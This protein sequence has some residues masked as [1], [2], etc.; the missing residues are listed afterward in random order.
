MS[1][2]GIVCI[3]F[4]VYNIVGLWFWVCLCHVHEMYVTRMFQLMY[5]YVVYID[6]GGLV[7]ILKF[8]YPKQ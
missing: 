8:N 2:S 7:R 6:H 1:V 4:R 5:I 3:W